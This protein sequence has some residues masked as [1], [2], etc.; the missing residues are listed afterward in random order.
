MTFSNIELLSR[1]LLNC[2]PPIISS[3]DLN[4]H[5]FNKENFPFRPHSPVRSL[6]DHTKHQLGHLNTK[7]LK[8]FTTLPDS[9]YH[10]YGMC[11]SGSGVIGSSKLDVIKPHDS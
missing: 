2:I 7:E 4:K 10:V 11:F 1:Q 5:H 3:S 8:W 6:G 9:F